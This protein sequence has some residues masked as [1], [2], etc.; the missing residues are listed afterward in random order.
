M[1][2]NKNLYKTVKQFST[3]GE[4]KP[5][6]AKIGPAAQ[7]GIVEMSAGAASASDKIKGLNITIESLMKSGYNKDSKEVKTLSDMIDTIKKG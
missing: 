4:K 3:S 5:E 2:K 7:P 1:G 6:A